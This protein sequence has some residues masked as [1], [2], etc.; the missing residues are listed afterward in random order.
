MHNST[1]QRPRPGLEPGPLGP[2]SNISTIRPLR[3]THYNCYIFFLVSG[4]VTGHVQQILGFVQERLQRQGHAAN[5]GRAW[6]KG[7]DDNPAGQ[8]SKL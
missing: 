2:E 4:V 1:T 3:L 8:W 5:R 7:V 6:K